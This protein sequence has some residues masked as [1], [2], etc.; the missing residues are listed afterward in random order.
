MTAHA[1]LV[2]ALQAEYE[3]LD[4][5]LSDLEP[6]GWDVET[7]AARF[8]VCD[9][10]FHLGYSEELAA[11]ALSDAP[12]FNARLLDLLHDAAGY[13]EAATRAAREHTPSELL[14]SWRE[15]RAAT[16]DALYRADSEARVPWVSGEMGVRSFA[17][18]RLMET[19]AHGQD[20]ADAL[21]TV[22]QDT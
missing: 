4:G 11:L 15:Q 10:V 22:R 9:Q 13:D 12:A 8:S 6:A 20:V 3:D 7:P 1:D 21:G 17:T 5:I 18:A 14:T 2:A 19:W 16:L